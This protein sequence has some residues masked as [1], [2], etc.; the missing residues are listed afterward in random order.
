MFTHRSVK[1]GG[2]FFGDACTLKIFDARPSRLN[3][4]KVLST[5]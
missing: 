1:K 2:E 4:G 5:K 3:S